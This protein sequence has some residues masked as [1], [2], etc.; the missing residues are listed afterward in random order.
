MGFL[1]PDSSKFSNR[2]SHS[3]YTA[4]FPVEGEQYSPLR[5]R[6]VHWGKKNQA[7]IKQKTYLEKTSTHL[8]LVNM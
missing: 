3:G 4:D 1:H 6:K 5:T 8:S 7:S 2:G